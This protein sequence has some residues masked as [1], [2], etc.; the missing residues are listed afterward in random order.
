MH[1]E[2]M[3]DRTV[4]NSV[5]WIDLCERLKGMKDTKTVLFG[6]G[7]WGE[8]M[9]R[10]FPDHPWECIIDNAPKTSKN[11]KYTVDHA[12]TF[13]RQ[14]RG[15]IVVISSYKNRDAMLAQ[16]ADYG[17][18]EEKIVDAGK[19]MYELTE[20]KIYFDETVPKDLKDG[21]FI[22]GGCYDGTNTECYIKKC[23]GRAACFEPDEKNISKITEKLAAYDGSY[24]I[25]PKALWSIETK[26]NFS[27]E[28]SLGSHITDDNT[29]GKGVEAAS[30][31]TEIGA[32]P[33]S[34]IK[35]DIEGAELEALRGA[36]ETIMRYKPVLAISIYHKLEDI[37]T[38]PQYI[39]E[40]VPEYRLYL[41]HYSFSD[42]DTVLYAVI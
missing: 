2:N 13:F 11:G 3:L 42:Y 23:H 36:K 5:I 22:D 28:G 31:D 18:P 21:L 30:I 38:I 15:E 14:Y 12:D 9:L 6:N 20:G 40:L 39:L 4:R 7:I 41:R 8:I 17:V 37:L 25:I 35:L 16:C 33:V 24:R 1:I 34:L 27:V 19:V 10:E 26:V 29:A 32:E